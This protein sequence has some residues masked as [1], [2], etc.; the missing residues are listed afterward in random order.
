MYRRKAIH[1]RVYN[2]NVNLPVRSVC[3]MKSLSFG[4]EADHK[5]KSRRLVD[6]TLHYAGWSARIPRTGDFHVPAVVVRAR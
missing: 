5:K 3:E 4:D 6:T 1:G 2:H